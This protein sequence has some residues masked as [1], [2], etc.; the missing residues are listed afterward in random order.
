MSFSIAPS[1][2]RQTKDFLNTGHIVARWASQGVG[3]ENPNQF[4]PNNTTQE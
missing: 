4:E 3:I 1:T 2:Q